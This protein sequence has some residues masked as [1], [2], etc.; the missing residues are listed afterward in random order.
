MH[1][2]FNYSAAACWSKQWEEIRRQ[3]PLCFYSKRSLRKHYISNRRE[4]TASSQGRQQRLPQLQVFL[5]DAH[6]QLNTRLCSH[7]T[8]GD[9]EKTIWS[10]SEKM[11]QK[12]KSKYSEEC[13]SHFL[14]VKWLFFSNQKMKIQM[15]SHSRFF[16]F[17]CIVLLG[18]VNLKVERDPPR[19]QKR[20]SLQ[21]CY[22]KNNFINLSSNRS[23]HFRFRCVL[24]YF[25]SKK[26]SDVLIMR[27][28]ID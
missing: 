25:H 11:L 23:W 22:L 7:L 13:L 8:G 2:P 16:I 15:L 14:K 19:P 3:K 9:E 20:C 5:K 10:G 12:M 27:V 24:P 6:T 28:E 26:E 17:I 21:G 4:S 18:S 1:Q